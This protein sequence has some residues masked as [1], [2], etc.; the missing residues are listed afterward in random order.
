MRLL[1]MCLPDHNKNPRPNRMIRFCLE[2]GEDVSVISGAHQE[3]MSV[4]K[5]WPLKNQSFSLYAKLKR[6]AEAFIRSY[7][8]P[9]KFPYISEAQIEE[10]RAENFDL[11]IV[12]DLFL[13]PDA[14]A[15]A[16]ECAKVIFDAREYYP[17]EYGGNPIFRMIER[18]FR[19]YLC[20][21][22]LPLCEQVMSVSDG[23]CRRYKQD[24]GVDV[25]LLRSAPPYV[26]YPVRKTEGAAI[27]MVHH[28]AA[29][30][31]RRLETMIETMA[32]LDERFSL[33]FYLTGN[34]AYLNELKAKAAPDRR[35]QFHDPVPFSDILPMLQNYD[36]G[37]Y[38]LQPT[39]FNTEYALPNKFFEFLQA[40]LMLAIGPS[41]D[42]AAL[43]ES[44]GCGIVA[45]NFSPRSMAE[46]LNALSAEDI[47]AAK[48]A[49][50]HAAKILCFEKESEKIAGLFDRLAPPEN[51]K[52]AV[53]A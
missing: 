33:D 4:R 44:Y 52:R 22:Y 39:G 14:F 26:D 1:M 35:I 11:I 7:I 27:R 13:L 19:V 18:P 3:Q 25:L 5:H 43:I 16:D 8:Y 17:E 38:L 2:R 36:I 20:K 6:K 28:G 34:T 48:Q 10:L 12:E 49:S 30:P 50:D 21:K 32:L 42:M 47:H 45:E 15:I 9:L 51:Q 46:K 53:S 29:N 37:F 40:R 23:L 41:P 31:D 24:F